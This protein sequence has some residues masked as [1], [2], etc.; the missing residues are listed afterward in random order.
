MLKEFK[1]HYRSFNGLIDSFKKPY[2]IYTK[3]WC[4]LYEWDLL[5]AAPTDHGTFTLSF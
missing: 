5:E 1:D 3:C 2:G 4:S